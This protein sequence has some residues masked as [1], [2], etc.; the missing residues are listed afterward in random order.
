LGQD[1]L[2]SFDRRA[3]FLKKKMK[4][5]DMTEKEI[6]WSQ[7]T[8]EFEATTTY[9]VGKKSLDAIRSEA[10]GL[11]DLKSAL[12]LGGGTG[13]YS[14]I[15]ARESDQLV[16][17]D[18]SDEMVDFAKNNLASFDNIKVEKASCL[19]LPYADSSFDTV[20]M[21]NLLHV[22][23][24]Q[25]EAI[26]EAKRVL[27]KNGRIIIISYTGEGMSFL[28]KMALM[29]RY[30]KSWGKPPTPTPLTVGKTCH[31]LNKAGFDI[32][33]ARLVGETT[34]AVLVEAVRS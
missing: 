5:T 11:K 28:S 24:A 2:W 12:E 16:V 15:L 4:G 3:D 6:F 8:D 22:I 31:M 10:A 32:V 18:L 9:V 7:F 33:S 29:Y 26:A 13:L 23:S 34:K 21:T 30:Y 14:Q 27:R 19:S 25:E 17:T 1:D 20:L